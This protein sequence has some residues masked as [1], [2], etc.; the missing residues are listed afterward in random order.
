MII[1]YE[2]FNRKVLRLI[3]WTTGIWLISSRIPLKK[4][5]SQRVE[6]HDNTFFTLIVPFCHSKK[7]H[8]VKCHVLPDYALSLHEPGP[9]LVL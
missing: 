7:K 1:S 9:C 4:N 8:A 2:N 5:N 3:R 6:L